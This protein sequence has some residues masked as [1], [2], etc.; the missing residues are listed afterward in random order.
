MG[1]VMVVGVT[2]IA[3]FFPVFCG[4]IKGITKESEEIYL[5]EKTYK[6]KK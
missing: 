1:L 3:T 4:I 5:G 6:N 2:I